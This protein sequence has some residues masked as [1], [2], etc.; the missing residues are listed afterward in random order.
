M[1]L[2]DRLSVPDRTGALLIDLDGVLL[3]TVNFEA[4]LVDDLLQA[5]IPTA[6]RIPGEVF[7]AAFALPIPESWRFILR[8]MA[9]PTADELVH[10][11]T[12]DLDTARMTGHPEVLPGAH[13]LLLGASSRLPTAVVSNNP[14]SQVRQ[15]L[16]AAGLL[17]EG[18]I[19]VG[20]DEGYASKPAPD[21]YA[22]A[23]RRLGVDPGRCAVIEDS[24]IGGS[25]ARA[26]GA[27]VV[28]VSTGASSYE[29]LVHF[30]S[31][32]VV[33]RDLGLPTVEC[34]PGDVTR[35]RLDTP[36]E[37]VS[38]MIEHIAWRSGCTATVDWRSDDWRE[39]GRAIGASYNPLLDRD[40]VVETIGLIDD[41]SARVV[42]RRSRSPT[43]MLRKAAG[44]LDWFLDLRVEQL[45]SGRSLVE[46]LEGLAQGAQVEIVIDVVS[47]EDAHHTWEAIFR[48]VGVCLRDLSSQLRQHAHAASIQRSD[49]PRFGLEIIEVSS[50][51][52]SVVRRTAE[53]VC[54]VELALEKSRF[55]TEVR[56]SDSVDMDGLPRLIAAM[57]DAAGIGGTVDFRATELSSSHVVAED[58][59]MTLGEAFRALASRKMEEEGIEGFGFGRTDQ[60]LPEVAISWE[61]RKFLKIMPIGWSD[62][63]LKHFRVGTSL[64]SGLF[65]EDLDDFLDGFV[66]GMSASVM[67]HWPQTTD[68]DASWE[69]IFSGLGVALHKALAINRPRRGLIAGVKATLA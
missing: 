49:S 67:V 26:V 44:D 29:E 60:N 53:S 47:M 39:L 51:H 50:R 32:D 27:F 34:K 24:M 37:F 61:G 57:A 6:P 48:G 58:I 16:A 25:A 8:A 65:S 59:G 45:A 36:N 55:I 54:Q 18:L 38:H 41:G 21:M 15:L 4:R 17:V 10:R 9:L 14:R 1:L 23:A 28:G 11:L 46:L 31:F 13:D 22:E 64:Q 30:Q 43:T 20:N 5:H 19:I 2:A 63:D 3:D 69:A 7:R 12:R 33:Y 68:L 40:G 52:V 66:G 62:R 56:A 42:L 35:K